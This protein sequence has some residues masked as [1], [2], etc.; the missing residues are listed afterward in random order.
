MEGGKA[1]AL[2]LGPAQLRGRQRQVLELEQAGQ[3]ELQRLRDVLQPLPSGVEIPR[4][5]LGRQ[6]ASALQLL[7]SEACPPV[8]QLAQ[9]GYDT[10]ANQAG[11]QAVLLKQLGEALVVLDAGL[12]QMP[13]R[14]Q[15][16]LITVS[17]FGRQ[18]QEYSTRGAD[19]GSASVALAY[20]E[21]GQLP[22]TGR[23]P[24]LDRVDR[25]RGKASEGGAEASEQTPV[26]SWGD[27]LRRV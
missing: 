10:H 15:V 17:E 26:P 5:G 23:Y 7:G 8:L 2:Q 25:M 11:R 9:A 20:G 4:S 12:G 22:L 1:L 19:H 3:R 21:A 27:L 13:N 16:R 24:S 14:S 6:V 18:L